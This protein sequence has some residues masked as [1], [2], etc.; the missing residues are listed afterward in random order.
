MS[1]RDL[2]QLDDMHFDVLREIGNIGAGNAA[3]S[4]AQMMRQKN[5]YGDARWCEF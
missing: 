2:G 3:T 4:L 5:G 1:I